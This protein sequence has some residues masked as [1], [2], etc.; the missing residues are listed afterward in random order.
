MACHHC[1]Q[2]SFIPQ[3]EQGQ[4][5]ICSVCD[6]ELAHSVE[7]HLEYALPMS[8]TALIL[9]A[10]SL[11]FTFI[12]FS[13]QG[14]VQSIQLTDAASVMLQYGQ[15]F[16]A[17]LINFT[18]IVLPISI[19]V[20]ILLLHGRAVSLL[21]KELQIWITKMLFMMKDWCMPE[22]FLVGVLVSLV[23]ITSLAEISIGLSFWAFA[24]FVICF[25]FTLIKLDK[26]AI[27]DEV[28]HHEQFAPAKSGVRAI[29]IDLAACSL[30]DIMTD[31]DHCPR[32]SGKV[33]IRDPHNLQKTLAWTITAIL[34][35]I[36]ANLY[37]I[38]TTVF[39]TDPQPS[40]IIEGV[41]LLWQ[42]GSYP[43]ATIIFVASVVVP[44]AKLTTLACLVWVVKTKPRFKQIS[45]TKI[46]AITEF[47]GKWSM[48][49]VFVVA[50]L[51][52]LIQ[53]TGILEV[54]PGSGALFFSAMVIASMMAAHAFDPKQLWDIDQ[55]DSRSN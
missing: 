55:S 54:V 15:P 24:S 11:S 5:A 52:A 29:D 33:I 28:A 4:V 38:M 21:P 6:G 22:I 12:S 41:A 16:L 27:W 44:I 2:I 34:L 46:Y 30:C 3:L 20:T 14:L 39:L 49:D 13:K 31:Q 53:L 19:L 47:L 25:I 32:C 8:V 10:L 7:G 40:T 42:S 23:K 43:I 51:V 18:I 26:M 36:P 37:P 48:I 45:F 1:D 50:V 17:M 35:Y 9:M